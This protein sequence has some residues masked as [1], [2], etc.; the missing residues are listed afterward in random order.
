[1]SCVV[2]SSGIVTCV[3]HSKYVN[4]Y[5]HDVSGCLHDLVAKKIIPGFRPERDV[6]GQCLLLSSFITD[7]LFCVLAA[8]VL[9]G[10]HR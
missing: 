4:N 3:V 10:V 7:F 8:G 2:T 6:R 1:M 5:A 9:D